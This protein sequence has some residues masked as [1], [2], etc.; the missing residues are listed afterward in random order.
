MHMRNLFALVGAALI[1]FVGAGWYLGWYAVEVQATPSATGHRQVN[2]D[3][4]SA[5]MSTD[6]KTGTTRVEEAIDAKLSSNASTSPV[7]E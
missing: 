5:K 7:N 6:L 4:D 3:I 1:G 2:I